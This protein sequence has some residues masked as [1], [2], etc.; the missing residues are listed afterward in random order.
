MA[1]KWSKAL[2][3]LALAFLAICLGSLVVQ[4][5]A[6]ATTGLSPGG[7]LQNPSVE[8][9]TGLLNADSLFL[10]G[11]FNDIFAKGGQFSDWYRPRA[12]FFFP[13]YAIFGLAYWL[14]PDLF[15]QVML[16][17]LFQTVLVIAAV[18]LIAR[19]AVGAHVAATTA[20]VSGALVWLALNAGQPFVYILASVFH[21]GAFLVSLF[22][23]GLWLLLHD[24]ARRTGRPMLLAAMAAL[25]FAGTVSNS[26]FLILC[27]VPL[28]GTA[29]AEVLLTRR[30][31]L[32]RQ[33]P[34]VAVLAAGV[35]GYVVDMKMAG[36][37]GHFSGV[38]DPTKF[39]YNFTYS[40]GLFRNAIAAWPP[41][42]ALWIFYA[43]IVVYAIVRLAKR[44]EAHRGAHWLALYS[45]MSAACCLSVFTL[46]TYLWPPQSRYFTA[47]MTWP[48]IVVGVFVASHWRRAIAPLAAAG[49][50][51][52]ALSI[53]V[54]TYAMAQGNELGT[55]YT[56]AENACID[57][58]LEGAG[59]RN[60]IA[61]YWDA[62]VVQLPSRLNL[63]IAQYSRD[64][65]PMHWITSKRYFKARYDF[66]ILSDYDPGDKI[67][68]DAVLRLNG[69]PEQIVNCGTSKLYLYGK[70]RLRVGKFDSPG[71][72]YRWGACELPTVIGQKTAACGMRKQDEKQAGPLSF[73]PYATLPAGRYAFEIHYVSPADK[74]RTVADWDVMMQGATPPRLTG[75]PMKGTDGAAGAVRGTFDVGMPS[76]G[77]LVEIRTLATAD[78]TLEI[79]DLRIDRLP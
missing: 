6:G 41:L 35:V 12:S 46:I 56:L 51:A 17:G 48:V 20:L 27:V 33:L 75:G 49:T 71:D 32:K 19:A 15:G 28:A 61:N 22:V 73:G 59:L 65:Y 23:V 25:V 24:P 69:Q 47:A 78:S 66:A 30:L 55:H 11:M 50:A 13:D 43:G 53:G 9:R 76:D 36:P 45:F 42:A 21:Y 57:N 37:S 79:L 31:S 5:M 18:W 39:A 16:Y 72:S 38:I 64:F 60:G 40:L 77:K 58:A 52:A 44:D 34:L 74:A 70:D 3:V 26:M 62:R 10:P 7:P 54:G 2:T 14:S 29:V 63:N 68:V 8:V 4:F 67:S 1:G